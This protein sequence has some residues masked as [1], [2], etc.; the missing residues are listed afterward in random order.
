MC[1]FVMAGSWNQA[2]Q[3][4]FWRV[5]LSQRAFVNP[6]TNTGRHDARDPSR[7]RCYEGK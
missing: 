4:T 3:K 7:R 5:S 1:L 6:F 2:T